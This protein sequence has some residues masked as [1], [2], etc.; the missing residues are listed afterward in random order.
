MGWVIKVLAAYDEPFWRS[1]GLSGF[2]VSFDDDLSVVFDN[3]PPDAGR[4]VLLGFLEGEAARRAGMLPRKDRR[5]LALDTLT[6]FFGPAAGEPTELVEHDWATEQWSRGAYS[7][8]FMPGGWTQFGPALRRPAG[9]IHFAGT[10]TAPVWNGY[11]DGAVRSGERAAA[12]VAALL[13]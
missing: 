12:E 6:K 11:M 9:R 10:E 7:G 3:S 1:D 5:R 2:L 4:G 8:R 13:A